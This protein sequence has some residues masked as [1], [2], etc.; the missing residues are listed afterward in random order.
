MAA[1][2]SGIALES[3]RFP[4]GGND[5]QVDAATQALGHLVPATMAGAVSIGLIGGP[6]CDPEAARA[7]NLPR[8]SWASA[9]GASNLADPRR[10]SAFGGSNLPDPMRPIHASNLPNDQRRR[11]RYLLD[12]LSC[13]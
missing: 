1:S 2:E 11:P 7:S 3:S 13:L 5:N 9:Y 8:P 12:G 4:R 10:A 6:S